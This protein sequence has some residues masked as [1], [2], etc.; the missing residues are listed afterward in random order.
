MLEHVHWPLAG[1]APG[2]QNGGHTVPSHGGLTHRIHAEPV[3][4]CRAVLPILLRLRV[5][6]SQVAGLRNLARDLADPTACAAIF[7]FLSEAS[8]SRNG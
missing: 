7:F 8:A 5:R 2:H 1:R 6:Y 3:D 4:G